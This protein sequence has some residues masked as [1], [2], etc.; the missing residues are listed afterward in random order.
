MPEH[1][2]R[3]LFH[4]YW[5]FD[6]NRTERWCMSDDRGLSYD[7]NSLH[8]HWRII[9]FCLCIVNLGNKCVFIIKKTDIRWKVNSQENISV[10]RILFSY[11][12]YVVYVDGLL[13]GQGK[14]WWSQM[15][16]VTFSFLFFFLIADCLRGIDIVNAGLD[17]SLIWEKG[18]WNWI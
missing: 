1:Y 15:P 16:L 8:R 2:S 10:Y 14:S 3:N 6:S 11:R 9:S 18:P 17:W 5:L 13:S 12:E 7:A 4:I